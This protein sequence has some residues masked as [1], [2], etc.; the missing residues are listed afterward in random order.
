MCFHVLPGQTHCKLQIF[1][2]ARG[3]SQQNTG[4][5]KLSAVLMSLFLMKSEEIKWSDTELR[6]ALEKELL[7]VAMTWEHSLSPASAAS[8]G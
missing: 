3:G 7:R 1:P 4:N 2:S 8:C 5:L 6:L